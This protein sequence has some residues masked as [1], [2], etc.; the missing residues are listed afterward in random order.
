MV[1]LCSLFSSPLFLIN[2]KLTSVKKTVPQVQ[3]AG[4]DIVKVLQRYLFTLITDDEKFQYMLI[5]YRVLFPLPSQMIAFV[6]LWRY[7]CPTDIPEFLHSFC[8]R[9]GDLIL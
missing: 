7:P 5:N 3:R 2:G 8:W 6:K 1:F 9:E 4:K